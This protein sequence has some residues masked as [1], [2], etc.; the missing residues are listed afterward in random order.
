MILVSCSRLNVLIEFFVLYLECLK[1]A[2][3]LCHA[4][5]LMVETADGVG[6]LVDA[7]LE[8]L[9]FLGVLH[10]VEIRILHRRLEILHAIDAVSTIHFVLVLDGRL[11]LS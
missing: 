8:E 11:H 3:A 2:Y 5:L 1:L 9:N 10:R 7:A 4:E 6:E